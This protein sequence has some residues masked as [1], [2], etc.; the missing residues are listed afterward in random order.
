MQA[1]DIMRYFLALSHEISKT[2]N[3]PI[4]FIDEWQLWRCVAVFARLFRG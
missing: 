3:I 2:F 4:N 1:V